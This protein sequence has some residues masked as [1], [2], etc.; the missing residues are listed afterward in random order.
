[1][2]IEQI[3][4]TQRR[5]TLHP[6]E[7]ATLIAAARWVAEGAEGEMPEEAVRQLNQVLDNYDRATQAATG[8][9]N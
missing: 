5:I 7:L 4:P 2:Q 8:S 1:M 3:R 9:E 6:Y